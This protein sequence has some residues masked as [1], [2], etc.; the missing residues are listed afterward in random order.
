MARIVVRCLSSA[1]AVAVLA[2]VS[3]SGPV[4]S[5]RS[6]DSGRVHTA[7]VPGDPYFAGWSWPAMT[8]K[9]DAAWNVTLGSPTVTIAV[10]DTGVTP[11]GDLAGALVPGVD[12]VDGSGSTADTNGHGTA[13]ASVIAARTDN[14]IGIAGVCGGC[15]IMPVRVFDATGSASTATVAAGITW[16]VDHG[17]DVVNLSLSGSQD[18]RVL[19]EAIAYATGHNVTVV[20]AAGNG[21]S[22]DAGH[23]GYPA[24][25]SPS[26]VRVGGVDRNGAL[27][28]WSNHG[29]W[30]DI[31]AP[32]SV[33]ALLANGTV[34]LG[35]QGTSM[36][37]PY[38][39]GTVGLM[40]SDNARLSPADVKRI[41]LA[42]GTSTAGLDV[43][44]GRRLDAYAA[45]V[46][47]GYTASTTLVA[48]GRGR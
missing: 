8:S 13:V 35:V 29:S 7:L 21:G 1:A 14:G 34:S 33:A 44:S 40:L 24:A 4:S 2:G 45:L 15:T 39:S 18:S 36:A 19:D 20:V 43:S 41:L 9:L 11:L 5:A 12:L 27:F 30:V 48:T 25:S 3:A 28:S 32:G 23:D 26:A 37:A 46:G 6:V 17:A 42:T 10:V 31:A 22:S 16:A 38:V 47:A